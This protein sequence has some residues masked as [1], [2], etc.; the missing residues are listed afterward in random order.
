MAAAH[1][2]LVDQVALLIQRT[3]DAEPGVVPLGRFIVGDE[4]F[5]MLSARRKAVR[6]VGQD[7]AG[8]RVLMRPLEGGAGW[9]VALYLPNEL[10]RVLE[11]QDP[12]RELHDGNV[13]EFATLVEEVDHVVTFADRVAR[14]GRDVSLLELEWH[15]AVTKFLVLNHFVG[16]LRDRD[17]LTDAERIFVEHHVFHKGEIAEA[18]PGVAARYREA[19]RLAL[20]FVRQ[21]SRRRPL[22]RIRD[23]RRFHRAS[24]HEKIRLFG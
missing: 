24:H 13:D 6:M 23:L 19:A 21:L 15:A 1:H 16:R 7:G 9:A 14:A 11:G 22:E 20:R 18:D 10:V 3:Y 4:G 8:A 2:P 5:R 12:R 17:T